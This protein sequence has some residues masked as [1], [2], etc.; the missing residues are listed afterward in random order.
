MIGITY[1]NVQRSGLYPLNCHDWGMRAPV[2]KTM[3]NLQMAFVAIERRLRGQ[4]GQGVPQGLAN[5]FEDLQRGLE[6]LTEAT[7]EEREDAAAARLQKQN[8]QAAVNS[9]QIQMA[10]V[11]LPS[12]PTINAIN[13]QQPPTQMQ[14]GQMQA[15]PF[16]RPYE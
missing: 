4:R 9:L 5:N 2:D 10:G 12:G 13:Q 3:A 1:L 8:L 11:I 16:G 6:G 7:A 14:G 15:P